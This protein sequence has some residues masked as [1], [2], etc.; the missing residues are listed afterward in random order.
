ML[1]GCVRTARSW[2][3]IF[4]RIEPAEYVSFGFFIWSQLSNVLTCLYR[5]TVLE[6]PGWDRAAVREAVDL[7][8]LIDEIALRFSR[9][10]AE[11]GLIDD[12]PGGTNI[13][14]SAV[15]SIRFIQATWE[16]KIAPERVGAAAPMLENFDASMTDPGWSPG[17]LSNLGWMSDMFMYWEP[18][19]PGDPEE[20]VRN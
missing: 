16:P 18:I 11:A 20:G 10:P 7:V 6:V 1:S 8:H 14:T 19:V 5:L 15:R 9:V 2:I 17:F 4:L 3:D 13:M 12:L